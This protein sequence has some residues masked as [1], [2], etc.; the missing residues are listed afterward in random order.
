MA[1]TTY[2][3]RT[4]FTDVYA[5]E[6]YDN[7]PCSL[8]CSVESS[9]P[10]VVPEGSGASGIDLALEV[11]GWL[12]G[13]IVDSV[14]GLPLE[15][16]MVSAFGPG[17]HV[18]SGGLT[19][20]SGDYRTIEPLHSGT[21]YTVLAEKVDYVDELY[22]DLPCMH[23]EC[24]RTSGDGVAV[25]PSTATAGIDFSLSPG[26]WI[27][28]TVTDEATGLPIS[29][30]WILGY[31]AIGDDSKFIQSTFSDDQGRYR[32]EGLVS[33]SYTASAEPS[34]TYI[35]EMYDD[36][37]CPWSCDG[38][39][40]TLIP[41]T[42]GS[43]TP[44]IDFSLKLGG[45]FEGDVLDSTTTLPVEHAE[46]VF[47]DSMG[48]YL[49]EGGS[50]SGH[51]E[52]SPLLPGD[53]YA[54]TRNWSGYLD[55]LYDDLPCVGGCSVTSGTPFTVSAGVTT[56]GIDFLLDEQT[57]DAPYLA[58]DF[59]PSADPLSFVDGCLV[60]INGE[61]SPSAPGC[62]AVE[63]IEWV[64]GD[65][66]TDFTDFPASHRYVPNGQ[67]AWVNVVAYDT[68]GAWSIATD[69]VDLSSC[70]L[71]PTSLVLIGDRVTSAQTYE[72]CDSITAADFQ[73]LPP[74]G[75]VTFRAGSEIEL[76]D[77]FIVDEGCSFTAIVEMP[78]DCP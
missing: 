60:Q 33:G 32:L 77:D 48:T 68:T 75:D 10:V 16:A 2:Y 23:G 28:G 39:L 44:D 52:V 19:D 24:D 53:Y 25:S 35:P 41:V 29:S 57:C 27:E 14:T 4:L 76:G 36:V 7:F 61:A 47:Y 20:A 21:E 3:V 6:A 74:D 38:S 71:P 42:Q 11:G 8:D 69:T 45:G 18:A 78:P 9:T 73:V 15:G 5:G 49:G 46:I 43:G 63:T 67:T 30:M 54:H 59:P 72:A 55:E 65:G 40:A 22:D 51:Y 56:A 1:P 64:W 12:E 58:V 50:W 62:Y 66:T 26:G 37:D 34:G 13:R 17:E 70:V 31:Q